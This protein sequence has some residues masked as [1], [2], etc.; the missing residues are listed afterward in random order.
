M[1]Q[2]VAEPSANSWLRQAAEEAAQ[3]VQSERDILDE[4]FRRG[5]VQKCFRMLT[6][7][8]GLSYQIADLAQG[9][10][11]ITV[12]PRANPKDPSKL[13]LDD[14][15]TSEDNMISLIQ[16]ALGHIPLIQEQFNGLLPPEDKAIKE[17][18]EVIRSNGDKATER[19]IME[20]Y[21][22]LKAAQPETNVKFFPQDKESKTIQLELKGIKTK[23]LFDSIIAAAATLDQLPIVNASQP[24]MHSIQGQPQMAMQAQNPPSQPQYYVPQQPP[25]PQMQPP[26]QNMAQSQQQQLRQPRPAINECS[27]APAAQQSRVVVASAG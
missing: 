20:N 5:F 16:R 23:D 7:Q 10:V 17:L 6:E 3:D 14:K 22:R 15:N 4:N 12:A 27:S 21:A 19:A 26:P 25:H 13:I 8:Q 1:P 11:L 9:G 2:A 18:E 24:D